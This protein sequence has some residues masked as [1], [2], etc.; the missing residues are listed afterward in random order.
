MLDPRSGKSSE[1]P[2]VQEFGF[3]SDDLNPKP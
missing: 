3:V 2:P 1:A